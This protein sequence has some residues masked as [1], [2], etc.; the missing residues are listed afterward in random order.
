MKPTQKELTDWAIAQIQNKYKDDIALLIA[1]SGHS[2]DND[3]HGLCFDYFVPANEN[4]NRLAKTFIIDGVGH[5]L[6]PRSWERIENMAKFDDDFTFGLGEAQILYSRNEE[7]LMRFTAMQA[8]QRANMQDKNFM[9]QKA[10]EKLN[11]GME[12]YRT[13][14][15]EDVPYKVKMAA[16]YI[17]H[18]LAIA[19]A[20]INGT[21]FK[22][23]LD[24]KT[25]ELA[26]MN[27][28]PENMIAYYE[29]IVKTKSVEEMKQLCHVIISTTRRFIAAHK[30]P[31][32]KPVKMPVFEDLASWYQECSLFWRRIYYHC[33]TRNAGRVFPDA[34]SLQREFGILKDE[35]GLHEMDLLG[36]FDVNDLGAFKLH[37]REL[38]L[39]IMREIASHG[40]VLNKYDNLEDFLAKNV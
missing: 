15:F 19:V 1:I 31:K 26:Q 30:P 16:G 34:L 6:Y 18:Y 36:S 14:M 39:Y 28:I 27:E 25:I 8:K 7:D 24:L 9:F 32:N 5:D 11:T 13:M 29:A 20:C 17:A 33:D 37:A 22:T 3:C 38:E 23:P 35:F 21:Y 4:G 40:V 12:L 2:L 10:L